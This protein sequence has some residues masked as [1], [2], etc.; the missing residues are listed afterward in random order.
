MNGA[1]AGD[2]VDF[3]GGGVVNHDL[4]FEALGAPAKVSKTYHVRA[5]PSFARCSGRTRCCKGRFHT[6]KLVSMQ[7]ASPLGA[8]ISKTFKGGLPVRCIAR[9]LHRE[10]CASCSCTH[11]HKHARVLIFVL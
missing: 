9:A 8:A 1:T 3:N 11:T 6:A 4:Y 7:A 5:R 2:L 10:R